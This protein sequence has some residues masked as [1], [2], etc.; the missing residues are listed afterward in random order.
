VEA[1]GEILAASRKERPDCGDERGRSVGARWATRCTDTLFRFSAAGAAAEVSVESKDLRPTIP[2]SCPRVGRILSVRSNL[3]GLHNLSNAL[4]AVAVAWAFG[5][6][7]AAIV[8]GIGRLPACRT[9]GGDSEPARDP[10]LRGL[11]PHRRRPSKRAVRAGSAQV[12]ADHRR[13]RCGG[14]GTARNGRGWPRW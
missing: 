4:A 5:I 13:L 7:E 6:P 8:E 1:F 12:A 3:V 14:T 11:R 10:R 9:A 2:S